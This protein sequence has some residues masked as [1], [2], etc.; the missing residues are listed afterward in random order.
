[1]VSAFS[2]PGDFIDF[3]DTTALVSS[4]KRC[5]DPYVFAKRES[6]YADWFNHHNVTTLLSFTASVFAVKK[7]V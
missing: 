1:V 4:S 7:N 2:S 6:F 3:N 5:V